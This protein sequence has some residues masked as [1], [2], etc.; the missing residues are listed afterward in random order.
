M[1]LFRTKWMTM[2]K[3][4]TTANMTKK[5]KDNRVTPQKRMTQDMI[6]QS[7]TPPDATVN[8]PDLTRPAMIPTP[9]PQP[10]RVYEPLPSGSNW[11]R[12]SAEVYGAYARSE[13]PIYQSH[14]HQPRQMYQPHIPFHYRD[15]F[16]YSQSLADHEMDNAAESRPTEDARHDHL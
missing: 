3:T 1:P 4:T 14:L 8:N 10:V 11:G 7:K 5:K 12:P 2:T 6:I 15:G 16:D 13:V 9:L